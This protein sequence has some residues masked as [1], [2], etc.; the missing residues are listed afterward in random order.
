MILFCNS[1]PFNSFWFVVNSTGPLLKIWLHSIL[2][3]FSTI[4]TLFPIKSREWFVDL[5]WDFKVLIIFIF[6]SWHFWFSL[7]HDNA[8]YIH[9]L[10]L[11]VLSFLTFTLCVLLLVINWTIY[12]TRKLSVVKYHVVCCD[13]WFFWLLYI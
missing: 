11:Y 13:R 7:F 10:S 8:W 12:R 6:A 1:L 3:Y 4:A 2:M 9:S 5:L